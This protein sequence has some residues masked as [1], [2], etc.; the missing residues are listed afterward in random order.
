M[1]VLAPL[2]KKT[3]N[4]PHRSP[5]DMS[6]KKITPATLLSSA[7]V[8]LGFSI[9]KD[10]L[11][12]KNT[13]PAKLFL[14]TTAMA[15]SDAEGNVAR[16]IDKHWPDSG[17]G[18]TKWGASADVVADTLS[19]IIVG[20]G[21][22][23]SPKI[24]KA[25]KAAIGVTLA[26]E[27]GKAKWAK[28]KAEEYKDLTGRVLAI[29]PTPEGKES[30]AEK[31]LGITLL[32]NTAGLKEGSSLKHLTTLA[33]FMFNIIGTKRSEEQRK[34]YDQNA[35]ELIEAARSNSGREVI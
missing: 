20:A 18:T 12:T 8:I 23:L 27:L 3:Q 30:M 17:R 11:S 16:F 31:Y 33:G 2:V 34:V 13:N 7:R 29:E 26:H 15:A 4:G 5:E 24:D 9:A 6:T 21:A 1:G 28:D 10:L 19:L 14:K 25:A 35:T 32:V 22:V